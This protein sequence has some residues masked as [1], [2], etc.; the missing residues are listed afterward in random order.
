MRVIDQLITEYQGVDHNTPV[1]NRITAAHDRLDATIRRVT[2]GITTFNI[3]QQ[4]W[5]AA[6]AA[7][8]AAS[9][10]ASLEARMKA[11]V[12]TAE[13]ASRKLRM[14]ELVAA[15]SPFT[16]KQL[17]DAAVIL[18]A[19]RINSERALPII[20]KLGAAMGA[21][22]AQIGMFTRA[23]GD[24]S[25]GRGIEIDV[26]SAM[27]MNR[28]DFIEQG[29][30]FDANGK[31]LSSATDAM[32]ALE[33]IVNS[34]YG[35]ILDEFAKTPEAKRASLED[36]GEKVMRSIGNGLLR[37][38][39]PTM[40]AVTKVFTGLTSS[41]VLDEVVNRITFSFLG[42]F[43]ADKTEIVARFASKVLAF[44][45]EL[46]ANIARVTFYVR[47]LVD[48]IAFDMGRVFD[49]LGKNWQVA[50]FN[51]QMFAGWFRDTFGGLIQTV[52]D[53]SVYALTQIT[54]LIQEAAGGLGVLLE[55]LMERLRTAAD[56]MG[57]IPL[58]SN[59]RPLPTPFPFQSWELYTSDKKNQLRPLPG[60][61]QLQAMPREDEFFQRIMA[62]ANMPGA[63]IPD[64]RNFPW[65]RGRSEQEQKAETV[66][67]KIEGNTRATAQALNVDVHRLLFGGG[68]LAA[69][70]VSMMDLASRRPLVGRQRRDDG[71]LR[72]QV[73]QSANDLER[74]V[75]SIIRESLP[76]LLRAVGAASIP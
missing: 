65:L 25:T 49:F 64:T 41:G 16:T 51:M 7:S 39:A 6:G 57:G 63:G 11:L 22:D 76:Q 43:G 38:S 46:P 60:L 68:D 8:A 15:P 55:G 3:A 27:G 10:Y 50:M 53:F 31:L 44:F 71:G 13:L 5:D 14:V 74:A 1:I 24:L 69:A 75:I 73:P 56:Q 52:R 72:L 19:F 62:P 70:G 9:S 28:N 40:E 23:I 33:R 48:T 45:D 17:A 20:G 18:E 34:R 35:N 4:V 30:K 58:L 32:D 67:E 2:A 59:L 29:I 61:P 36:A 42:A 26:L 66:L 21:G 47:Q 12:G 37:A 54:S